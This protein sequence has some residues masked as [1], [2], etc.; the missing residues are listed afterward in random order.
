MFVMIWMLSTRIRNFLRRY[1][2]TNILLAALHTRRGLKWGVPAMLLAVP[3]LF[4]VLLCAEATAHTGD[5]L[6]N[7][8]VLLFVWNALKF[9]VAGPVL[10]ARLIYVRVLEVRAE[11]ASR[12]RT[13]SEGVELARIAIR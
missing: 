6:L 11:R 10:L 5:G 4:G 1:A 3:Y 9:L 8:L 2:P 13:L 7:I 12:V